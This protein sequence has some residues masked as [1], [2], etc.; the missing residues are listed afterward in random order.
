MKKLS[1]AQ[2]AALNKLISLGKPST[3]QEIKVQIITMQSLQK[4]G[5]VKPIENFGDDETF[6]REC[7][8]I[9]W[10]LTG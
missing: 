8:T 7:E 2:Q 6:G 4:A 5:H 10:Q 1:Q 9:H 3:S